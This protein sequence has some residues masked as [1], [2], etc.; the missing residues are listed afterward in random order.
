MGLHALEALAQTL[1]ELGRY[2]EA[3]DAALAAV[4]GEPLRESAHR[5]LIA[6][7]VAEGNP[8]EALRQY[9]RYRA[10]LGEV[11]NLAPSPKMEEL[12]GGVTRR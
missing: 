6:V 3:A 4:A 8:S 11:L 12:V 9:E 1:T 2:S 5:T 7:H 10:M